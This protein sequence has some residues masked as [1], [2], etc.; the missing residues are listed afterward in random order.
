MTAQNNR[1]RVMSNGRLIAIGIAL[2]LTFLV[3]LVSIPVSAVV[4]N[5]SD[6]ALETV[7]RDAIRIPTG[8]I[9]D[10]DLIGLTVLDASDRSIVNLEGIQHCSYLVELR[11]DGNEIADISA[12]SGLTNLTM[13][14]LSN[15][16]IV[17]I[18]VL[19]DNPRLV[20]GDW[21][22]LRYNY[23][24]LTPTS[25]DIIH[26]G[27]LQ[28]RGVS[29]CF[30]PQAVVINF[31][32]PG[33]EAAI[34][35]AIGK[36]TGDVQDTDLIG[37]TFLAAN[38]RKISNLEGIQYC[39]NLTSLNLNSNQIVNITKLSGLTTL[40]SLSLNHNQIV[41]ISAL[42][43]LGNLSMLFLSNNEIVDITPLSGLS[44]YWLSLGS[45]EIVDISSLS[46][47]AKLRDLGLDNNQI[48][49]ISALS[50][51]TKLIELNLDHNK[52]VDI[53]ALLSLTNLIFLDLSYNQIVDIQVLVD[54][55]RLV[56][57]DWVDLRYNYLNIT[58]GSPD[59]MDIEALQDRGVDVTFDPQ[60]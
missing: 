31:P 18:Q 4:V 24:D 49:D 26:I 13:L 50:S 54:N 22:D 44:F 39:T 45:N 3:A 53:S 35:D 38:N 21:V 51:S 27:I 55:P 7:I 10:T 25:P 37:L 41:D 23:L 12:L 42:S 15:N 32:D 57:G 17:D 33:L 59:M 34:R 5:F 8:D 2:V 58:P 28:G 29:V 16:E 6:P 11:L 20:D 56:D 52:I 30:D 40:G 60:D 36:P 43:N 1:L 19:V 46:G 9:Q 14:D 48:S 47:L